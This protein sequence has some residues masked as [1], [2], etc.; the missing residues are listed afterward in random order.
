[1]APKWRELAERLAE[2]IRNGSRQPGS[3]LPHIPELVAAGEGS[4]ATVH[5]AYK[6][7]ASWGYVTSRR[8]RGTVVLGAPLPRVTLNRYEPI[9]NPSTPASWE[10]TAAAEFLDAPADVAE[11][12]TLPAA[13]PVVRRPGRDT[14]RAA[15]VEEWY[16]LDVA[17]AS[18]LGR[19]E[20]DEGGALASLVAA[21]IFP[22]QAEESVSVETA[23]AD[24]AAQLGL[25][26][27]SSVLQIDRVTRDEA[28]RAIELVR[29]VAASHR[30]RLVYA[31]LPLQVR[32]DHEEPSPSL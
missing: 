28:G 16:P 11:L 17:Q 29:L 19:T 6:E 18:G 24:Q 4:T 25:S 2:E 26:P 15:L 7:L 14:S 10:R 5:R 30:L 22:A 31:P 3:T 1:M 32:G 20:Q 21:G 23:T 27:S 12:L 13:A 9:L 8:G